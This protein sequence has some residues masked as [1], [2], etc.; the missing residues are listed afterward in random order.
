[1]RTGI[2]SDVHGNLEALEAVLAA[3]AKEGVERYWCLGD[4]V[5]YCANPNECVARVRQVSEVVVIG[6]HDAACV[7]AEEIVNFNP[8]A[9][10]AVLWTMQ[11]L[12]PENRDWLRRLPLTESREGVLLVHSSPFEPANW[13]YI[14]TRT[15]VGEM[16]K[17]FTSTKANCAFVGH[18]HQPLIFV[19]KEEEFYRFLGDRLKLEDGSRYLINVGSAGQPRDGNPK[20]S[21]VI[22]DPEAGEISVFRVPYD[23]TATQRKIREAGLPSILAD[24]LA[25][26][27]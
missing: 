18:S 10:D 6:N 11:H 27:S 8:H 16:A 3:M 13:H 12:T 14:H 25:T 17:G 22:Y 2:F 21:F 19:K 5:G 9:R 4:V 24:R 1:M 7:G 26:G 23:I 20:A 15:H